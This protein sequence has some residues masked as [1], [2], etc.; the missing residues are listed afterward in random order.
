M[1]KDMEK[2]NGGDATR[3]RL[4]NETELPPKLSDVGVSKTQSSRWQLQSEL[5][6]EKFEEAVAAQAKRRATLAAKK[7]A[8]ESG[9]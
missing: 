6:D 8:A 1:L 9:E 3:A 7:A 4:L 2:Q 5:P